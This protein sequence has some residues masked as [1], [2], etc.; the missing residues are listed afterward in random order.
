MDDFIHS[1]ESYLYTLAD[2]TRH[3]KSDKKS[4]TYQH[5]RLHDLCHFSVHLFCAINYALSCHVNT[6]RSN[7]LPQTKVVSTT[8]SLSLKSRNS[9]ELTGLVNELA[10]WF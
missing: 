4:V 9:C 5:P 3:S 6:M 8:E 7:T 2:T 1:V 10:N